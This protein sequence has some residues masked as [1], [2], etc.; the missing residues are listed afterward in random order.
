M[1]RKMSGRRV[2]NPENG[3]TNLDENFSDTGSAYGVHTYTIEDVG[4]KLY[5]LTFLGML[6][7]L[8]MLRVGIDDTNNK[9]TSVIIM[10]SF[11]EITLSYI[12]Q[13]VE[14]SFT[15]H[16]MDRNNVPV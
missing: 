3:F 7:E 1:N 8:T 15:Y 2:H 6:G 11:S 14:T 13:L 4:N 16:P 12:I 5:I 9:F 10:N